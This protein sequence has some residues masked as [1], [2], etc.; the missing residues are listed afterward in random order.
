LGN[1]V[2]GVT[3]HTRMVSAELHQTTAHTYGKFEARIQ[4]TGGDGINGIAVLA[5]TADD[6]AGY[7]GTPPA[8]TARTAG[9]ASAGR[10]GAPGTGGGSVTPT[11]PEPAGDEGCGCRLVRAKGRR[12]DLVAPLACATLVWIVRR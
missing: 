4:F 6:A 12:S 8:D 1:L 5:L 9:A 7:S 3:V 10:A 11:A 2:L